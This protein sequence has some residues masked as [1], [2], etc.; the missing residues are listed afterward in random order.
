MLESPSS[1]VS[2]L[3]FVVESASWRVSPVPFALESRSSLVSALP[4]V[5]E[6]PSVPALVV[7]SNKRESTLQFQ[8]GISFLSGCSL[9]SADREIAVKQHKISFLIAARLRYSF[10][11]K[12]VSLR[13]LH[14][15]LKGA[16][17]A[18]K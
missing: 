18:T 8:S 5:L 16:K 6:P 4:F 14:R 2:A 12:L 15:C 17:I 13:T 9:N 7:A 1:Q 11:T 10:T 3:V